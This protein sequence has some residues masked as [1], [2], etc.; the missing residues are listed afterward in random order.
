MKHTHSPFDRINERIQ[1]P[2]DNLP[3]RLPGDDP[4]LDR[5]LLRLSQ[6]QR[7]GG[8]YAEI[9]LSKFMRAR[10]N[11]PHAEECFREEAAAELVAVGC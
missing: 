5:V 7:K 1:S 2:D 6:L 9:G 10:L 8:A 4:D 3:L 11:L